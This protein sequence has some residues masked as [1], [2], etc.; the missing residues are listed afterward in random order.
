MASSSS[1]MAAIHIRLTN[2][3]FYFIFSVFFF[4]FHFVKK[5]LLR[6]ASMGA[7]KADL[8]TTSESG[9]E[10][11]IGFS[12]LFYSSMEAWNA[13]DWMCPVCSFT[14]LSFLTRRIALL[15]GCVCTVYTAN[16]MLVLYKCN[17]VA[18]SQSREAEALKGTETERASI[19][20]FNFK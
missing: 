5:Y 20:K 10:I 8:A 7:A 19:A 18:P 9:H 11:S 1:S 12:L 15:C 17:A 14:L 6:C 13:Y 2:S 4:C 3:L 16:V